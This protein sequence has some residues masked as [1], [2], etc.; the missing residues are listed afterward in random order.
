[1]RFRLYTVTPIL[2]FVLAAAPARAQDE[3]APKPEDRWKA[4]TF[5]DVFTAMRA[6]PPEYDK[7][8]K[9]LADAAQKDPADH[10]WPQWRAHV[11]R[12]RGDFPT[13]LTHIKRARELAPQD[14]YLVATHIDILF[15]AKSWP[16]ARKE[17]SAALES[18]PDIAKLPWPYAYRAIAAKNAGDAKSA[19]EDF[20]KAAP[21]VIKQEPE[22]AGTLLAAMERFGQSEQAIAWASRPAEK[23]PR[24]K[25]ILANLHLHQGDANKAGQIINQAMNQLDGLDDG[26]RWSVLA[27]AGNVYIQADQH[28]LAAVCFEGLVDMKPDDVTSLNN[29]SYMLSECV[30][31]P[32]PAKA[33]EI[34]QK[35]I[36]LAEDQ[37][38]PGAPLLDTHGWNLVLNGKVDE[39]LIY[40]KQAMEQLPDDPDPAI[41]LA[42]AHLRKTPPDTKTAAEYLENAKKFYQ[43]KLEAK[44]KLDPKLKSRLESAEKQFQAATAKPA[45]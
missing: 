44:E 43:A 18:H 9:L 42:K 8:D 22:Q 40:L 35:A 14:L 19:E 4:E 34:S 7:A 33:L 25:A 30:S 29:L 38:G 5:R 15:D 1:M 10:R 24:W 12:L 37:G 3:D 2:I 11:A 45:E 32:D 13:A 28:D 6:K 20:A 16:E 39:G 26:D 21:L 36:K 31:K 17:I 27:V 41:H 23:D